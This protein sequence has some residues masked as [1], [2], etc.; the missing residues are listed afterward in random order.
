MRCRNI[1]LGKKSIS[2]LSLGQSFQTFKAVLF[3]LSDLADDSI[4]AVFMS[5]LSI[6][7]E[8]MALSPF[9]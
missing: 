3:S 7:S 4:H 8:V 9:I 6:E 2:N 5:L 1:H